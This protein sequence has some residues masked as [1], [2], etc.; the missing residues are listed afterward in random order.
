MTQDNLAWRRF[1]VRGEWGLY[2]GDGA[3]FW[4]VVPLAGVVVFPRWP[5]SGEGRAVGIGPT[6]LL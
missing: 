3:G 2:G 6:L 4:R 1:C 5:E